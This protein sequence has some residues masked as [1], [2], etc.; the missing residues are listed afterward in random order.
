MQF[1]SGYK[2]PLD[3]RVLVHDATEL[4]EQFSYKFSRRKTPE[5]KFFLADTC[6]FTRTGAVT[7]D[8]VVKC[9]QQ[10]DNVQLT[11]INEML[12]NANLLHLV[13][14]MIQLVQHCAM[15]S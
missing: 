2:Y 15:L 1:A 12:F 13:N 10:W 3:R 14:A 9:R 4:H 6:L 8:E 11:G 7:L 5:N